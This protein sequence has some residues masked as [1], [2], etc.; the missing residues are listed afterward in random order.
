M[1][2]GFSDRELER[3]SALLDRAAQ[4]LAEAAR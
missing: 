2:A 1:T 3:L 4:N